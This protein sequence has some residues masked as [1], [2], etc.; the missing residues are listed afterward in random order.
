MSVPYSRQ[1]LSNPLSS[2]PHA[3]AQ[4]DDEA[5]QKLLVLLSLPPRLPFQEK[6]M[7]GAG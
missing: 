5:D 2:P 7:G 6:A 3:L 4:E 1:A